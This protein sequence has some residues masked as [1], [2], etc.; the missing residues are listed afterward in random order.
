MTKY[1]LIYGATRGANETSPALLEAARVTTWQASRYGD[2]VLVADR[3]GIEAEAVKTCQE[4][5]SPLL[6]VGTTVRPRCGVKMRYY[7]RALINA[8]REI[9]LRQYLMRK[10]FR[11]VVIGNT[12]DC[13]AMATYAR[14]IKKPCAHY[15]EGLKS[16]APCPIGSG[17]V[18][19]SS[20]KHE[21]TLENWERN[22]PA[23]CKV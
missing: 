8:N 7:E 19:F 23:L 1:V 10:A 9:E 18:W 3:Y 11:V 20:L 15:A 21:W 2:V 6:V 5:A 4:S 16:F 13:K 12:A 14:A 17:H 22:H